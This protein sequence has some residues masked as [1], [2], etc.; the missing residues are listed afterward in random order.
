M[1]KAKQS[2]SKK[3]AAIK[4]NRSFFN[5]KLTARNLSAALVIL[6]VVILGGYTISRSFAA[7]TPQIYLTPSTST[8]SVNDRV[9]VAVRIDP[10]TSIDGVQ[11]DLIYDQNILRFESVDSAASAFTT[12]LVSSGANG[13]IHLVRGVLAPNVVTTDSL[14]ANITFT[15]LASTANTA[16]QV[17]GNATYQGA[18]TNPPTIGATVAVNPLAPPP[19]T[20]DTIL[21]VVSITGPVANFSSSNKILVT[22]TASDNASVNKMEVYIDGGIVYTTPSN[23]LSYSW[24]VKSRRVTKGPHTIVVKAYDPTGNIG[25]SNLTVYKT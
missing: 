9:T 14:V 7:T 25:V 23:S 18:Y 8:V 6:F 3:S 15:A 1:G 10:G 11:A 16:L 5:G 20:T 13:A 21:P 24:S 22:A 19:P 17:T 12:Q 4:N 2:G